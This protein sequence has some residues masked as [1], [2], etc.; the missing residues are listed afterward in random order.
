MKSNPGITDGQSF[1]F[2]TVS[3]RGLGQFFKRDTEYNIKRQFVDLAGRVLMDIHFEVRKELGN[4]T[5]IPKINLPG[6]IFI[7]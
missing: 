7:P 3:G 4:V 1:I 5:L 2:L 6:D